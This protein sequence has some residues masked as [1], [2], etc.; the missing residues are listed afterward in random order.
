LLYRVAATVVSD[1]DGRILVYRRS[2]RAGVLAGWHDVLV[3]G[4]V[5]AGEC[6][7]EAAVRELAEEFGVV[8]DPVEMWRERVDHPSGPCHLSVHHLRVADA[9]VLAADARE[10]G[11][12]GWEA[13]ARLLA[14][15]PQPFN[16]VGRL[17]LNRLAGHGTPGPRDAVEEAD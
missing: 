8:G 4:S 10:V 5:R 1:P 16:P 12:Y 14:R 17:A 11:W 3:G 2:S 13:P 15:P 6:Y 9:G 7:R